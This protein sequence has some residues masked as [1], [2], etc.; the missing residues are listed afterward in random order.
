[1]ISCFKGK[2]RLTSPRG[3]RVLNGVKGTAY[4]SLDISA[5]T[6][7][8]NKVGIYEYKEDGG[9][10]QNKYSYD[11]TVDAMIRYSKGALP[12]EFDNL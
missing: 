12:K 4:K 6:G 9:V 2:F 5:F 1:M 11:D 7:I 3:D 10:K 8:P